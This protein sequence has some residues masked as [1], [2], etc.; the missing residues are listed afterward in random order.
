MRNF[1]KRF[2]S[3][4]SVVALTTTALVA[5]PSTASATPVCT[6]KV[7]LTECVGLTS[8]GAQYI[9]QV[10][11]NF[12][13][14]LFLFSHGY[15]YPID[16][17]AAIPRVGGYTVLKTP[18]PAPGQS[19]TQVVEVATALLGRGYAVGGSG[20]ASQGWNADS[21]VK[22]N[23]ELVGIIKKQ[24]P[25]VKKVVAW[26]E[27]LGAFITQGF[28]E[29]NPGLVDS[30]GLLCPAAGSVE[31]SLKMAGDALWGI[32]TFFDPEIKGGNYSAGAAGVQQALGDIVRVLTV[33]G[34]L[35]AAFAANPL[36]PAW[37]ATSKVPAAMQAGIPSRSALTL[38]ALMSGV[39]TKSGSFDGATG[40]GP[41][42]GADAIRFATGLSPAFGALENVTNAAILGVLAT[43]D[44]ENQAGGAVF[45]NTKTDYAAQLGDD[46]YAFGSALSGVDATTMMLGYLAA[47]PKATAN[48][49]AVTKM[50]ALISHKGV[51]S[52]PTIVVGA[53][54]DPVTPA[55]NAQWLVNKAVEN[56]L[57]TAKNKNSKLAKT[58]R[59]NVL[60]LWQLTPSNYT[61]FAGASPVTQTGVNGTGHCTTTTKQYVAIA[62]MLAYS[63]ENG[64]LPPAG[65]VKTKARKA[66]GLTFDLD[67]SAPLLKYYNN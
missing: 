40:P 33:A 28:A 36:Q 43:W 34:S 6:N 50:R 24:F 39:P 60:A 35:S 7:I 21:G 47:A 23:V 53:E 64:A 10:P 9:F 3:L 12:G 61:K 42:S 25:T 22:T 19:A 65:I 8:D 27:S 44:V 45:D 57:A 32:K 66:G 15:R 58:T 20:F 2:I 59:N 38:V 13:G 18:Q 14:T 11:A 56:Y 54:A 41:V 49:A 62:E 63:A 52:D 46:L 17:P 55:G 26:G 4:L 30:V 51:F 67:F 16:I 5:A 37:P 31:A 1:K 29:T 48:A